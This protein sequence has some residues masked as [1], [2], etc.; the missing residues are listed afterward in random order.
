MHSN[1]N[2]DGDARAGPGELLEQL[3]RSAGDARRRILLSGGTVVTMD[4][5]LGDFARADVLVEG[6]TIVAVE[7]RLEAA[8]D[9]E[10]II[11]PAD[12]M[13]V[14]PGMQDTHRH[15]WQNQFR[16]LIPACDLPGYQSVM[17][18]TLAP[19]YRGEDAYAANL[20]SALGAL[21]AGVTTVLDFSHNTRTSAHAEAA[22]QALEEVG[23]R[24]VFTSAPP[25]AGAWDERWPHDMPRLKERYFASDDQL[26]TLR[27]GVYG[28]PD[29][30]GEFCALTAET[31]HFARNLGVSISVDGVFGPA[32]SATIE[33]LGRA[34]LLGPDITLIHCN[35]LTE[36]AW[37]FIVDAGVTVSLCPTSDT[38]IG[39]FDALPPIQKVLDL[40]IGPGLSVDVE[41]SL[42][43]DMFT[44]MQS[45]YTTQRML[46]FNRAYS[47][48]E[49]AP[50]PI[51]PR[52]VLEMATVHGAR[53]NGLGEVGTLA[54]GRQADLV[55]IGAE[56]VNTMPLNNAVATI[57]LG[58]DSRNVD[59][60]FVDGQVR[61]WSGRCVGS[62][63][64]RVRRLVHESRDYLIEAS[65]YPL[66]V[67]A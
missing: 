55:M 38:Q 42:S 41:C 2:G 18:R 5:H 46:A 31:I 54:P 61:K 29:I 48:D 51:G 53:V 56:D 26:L 6:E 57:V 3:E 25:L 66:D 13:I 28:A 14:M 7:P 32:S 35:D 1:A 40:G 39:I 67:V 12:G 52:A 44:Q 49:R 34:E 36:Q 8:N 24:A 47:G 50:D 17:L 19:H 37:K 43:T 22:I 27:L 62:D 16:R 21:D 58:A 64:D 63:L 15:C 9:G 65:G 45:I 33:A 11:V 30:G 4:P 23:V 59:S 10:A 60:V 20:I